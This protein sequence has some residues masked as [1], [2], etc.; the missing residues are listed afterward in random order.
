VRIAKKPNHWIKEN[1]LPIIERYAVLF[2]IV[3]GFSIVLGNLHS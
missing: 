2:W 3:G 1:R